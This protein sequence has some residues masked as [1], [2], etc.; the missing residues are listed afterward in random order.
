M[1]TIL[2]FQDEMTIK[3]RLYELQDLTFTTKNSIDYI[4]SLIERMKNLI[5]FSVPYL[6]YLAMI[7]LMS[8]SLALYLVPVNYLFMVLGVYKFTRKL[9]NPERVP[10]NDLLD[11]LSRVP[12]D[13][14]LKEWRELKVP[15]PNLHRQGSMMKR[16]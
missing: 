11:F 1:I 8:T 2:V 12:D 5:F 9:L 10:N 14:E 15:E 7:L 16:R 6:S 4:V 3:A 13:K